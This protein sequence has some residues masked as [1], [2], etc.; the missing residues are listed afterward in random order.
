MTVY[1]SALSDLAS[2]LTDGDHTLTTALRDILTADLQDLI[3]A[4]LTGEPPRR[5]VVIAEDED[6][7]RP[8][9][10]IAEGPKLR[11]DVG[12][13]AARGMEEIAE[14]GRAHV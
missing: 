14:I 5:H 6:D 1:E 7:R 10:P 4:E 9:H 11:H 2:R 12:S 13:A 3:E 8:C